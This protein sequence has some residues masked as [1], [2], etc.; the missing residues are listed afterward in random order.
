MTIQLQL[1]LKEGQTVLWGP[2]KEW[3]AN[4]LFIWSVFPSPSLFSLVH[5]TEGLHKG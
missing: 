4:G 2:R 5:N 1:G 3:S